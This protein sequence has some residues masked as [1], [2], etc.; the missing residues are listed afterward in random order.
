MSRC[1]PKVVLTVA[2]CVV[3]CATT[4]YNP[5]RIPEEEFK[6]KIKRLALT[7][8]EVF[9]ELEDMEPVKAKLD[10]IIEARLRE[11][12][13]TT[14]PASE[15]AQVEKKMIELVGGYFDPISGK[16]DEAKYKRVQEHVRREISTKYEGHAVLR[17]AIL[18][19]GA[20]FHGMTANWHGVQEEATSFASR[21]M[22]G[23]WAGNIPAS[24]LRVSIEDIQG[25]PLYM[26]F[27]GLELLS[28][29]S[30]EFFK[31]VKFE[32]VPRVELFKHEERLRQAVDIALGPLVGKPLSS[33]QIPVDMP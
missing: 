31:G 13:F 11:A 20:R 18:R 15:Y 22:G 4:V 16:K 1:L 25:N 23:L 8:V 2:L 24:S 7:P 28:K 14:V 27:G 32:P 17:P 29:Y 12:G 26:N 5:F 6:A 10:A 33:T 19:I 9:V 30:Y 21:L 3:G